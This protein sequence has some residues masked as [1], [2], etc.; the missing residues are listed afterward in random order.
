MVDTFI[1]QT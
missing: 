1:H